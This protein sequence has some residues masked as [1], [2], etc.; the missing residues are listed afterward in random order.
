MNTDATAGKCSSGHRYEVAGGERMK[1]WL[2][3]ELVSCG[4]GDVRVGPGGRTS[5]G[6]LRHRQ[7]GRQRTA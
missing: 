1:S 2:G 5:P 6:R 3:K 4:E 7:G